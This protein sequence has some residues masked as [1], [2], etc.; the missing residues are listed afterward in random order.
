MSHRILGPLEGSDFCLCDPEIKRILHWGRCEANH[1]SDRRVLNGTK[2][3]T[4][5]E[6]S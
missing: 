6:K 5:Q 4:V 1:L 2:K 3:N